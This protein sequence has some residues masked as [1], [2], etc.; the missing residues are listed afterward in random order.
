MTES[1]RKTTMADRYG[2]DMQFKKMMESSN[3]K[4]SAKD[5]NTGGASVPRK[6]LVK[7]PVGCTPKELDKNCWEYWEKRRVS[8]MSVLVAIDKED[9]K[10]SNTKGHDGKHEGARK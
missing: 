8:M 4:G 2:D 6:K 7:V 1:Y 5:N 10:D 9:I 3:G